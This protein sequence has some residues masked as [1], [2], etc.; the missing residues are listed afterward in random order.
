MRPSRRFIAA[1]FDPL[2]CYTKFGVINNNVYHLGETEDVPEGTSIK[3][4]LTRKMSSISSKGL[5]L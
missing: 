1:Y 3:T 5:K 4:Q 2:V